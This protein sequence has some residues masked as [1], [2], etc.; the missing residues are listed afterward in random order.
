MSIS[1]P[2]TPPSTPKESRTTWDI[3]GTSVVSAS[4]FTF[5]SQVLEYSADRWIAEVSIDPLTRAQAAPWMAFLAKLKG[6]VG[7]FRWGPE[8]LK[9]AQGTVA[10]TPLV[11]G[12]SQTGN[13]LDTDGWTA[14]SAILKAGDFIQIDNSFYQI[15]T[16]VSANG[17]GEAT[18]D[19][20]P[21]LR[22]HADNATIITASPK[23][24]L[25]LSD[26]QIR[27]VEAPQDRLFSI[28]FSA[29][30]AL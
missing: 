23:C 25:R 6:R 21:R 20:R 9:T 29:E 11:K 2:L 17:S 4:P 7:T 16:D 1:Y 13:S 18:L 3:Q 8:L 5:K 15:L 19:V 22:T 14:G 30:E 12:G 28:G 26:D 24:L 27:V 10:G